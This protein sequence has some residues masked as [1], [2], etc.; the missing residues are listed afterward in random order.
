M[1]TEEVT[2]LHRA[3][4]KR[5]ETPKRALPIDNQ[6]AVCEPFRFSEERGGFRMATALMTRRTATKTH[7]IMGRRPKDPD[8]TTYRG[9]FAARLRELRQAKFATQG[10]FVE[11]LNGAGLDLREVTV[12]AWERGHSAP[13]FGLLPT[14]AATL[15]ISIRQLM[16]EK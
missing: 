7:S 13:D 14:I 2:K 12:S 15:G 5:G 9:R 11:A 6:T 1:S 8:L 10:D 4:K 16:P 3:R